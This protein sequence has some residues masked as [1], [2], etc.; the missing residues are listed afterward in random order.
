MT[1]GVFDTAET[2]RESE[3]IE[4][5]TVTDSTSTCTTTPTADNTMNH[6]TGIV[7]I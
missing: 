3:M 2:P 5:S 6:I 4:E 1:T 7:V